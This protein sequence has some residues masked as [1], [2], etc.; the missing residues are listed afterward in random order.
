MAIVSTNEMSRAML[1]T[2]VDQQAQVSAP[3]QALG[4]YFE[5]LM[6]RSVPS[7]HVDSSIRETIVG[8]AIAEEDAQLQ[9]VPND[10][11]FMM[12]Q[13][14]SPLESPIVQMNR[15]VGESL[16]LMQEMAQMTVDM[17]AKMA[18]VK[19]TKGSVETLMKNQ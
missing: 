1:D 14:I 10:L 19:A 5:Q 16:Y 4:D 3:A 9:R 2:V 13:Q 15:I 7:A 8:K 12:Q 11:L 18:I 17:K 6:T